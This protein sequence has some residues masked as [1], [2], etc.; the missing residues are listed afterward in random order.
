MEI[1][2]S[3]FNSV[4]EWMTPG[5]KALVYAAPAG[6]VVIAWAAIRTFF[7][8]TRVDHAAEWRARVEYGVT[9]SSSQDSKDR[10]VGAAVLMKLRDPE[11][12]WIFRP[13]K[14]L[15]ELLKVYDDDIHAVIQQAN[16]AK[17]DSKLKKKVAK[18]QNKLSKE[19][20]DPPAGEKTTDIPGSR[21]PDVREATLQDSDVDL[22]AVGESSPVKNATDNKELCEKDVAES[23]ASQ[24][25]SIEISLI[26]Q[27]RQ[28]EKDEEAGLV[29]ALVIAK[30]TFRLRLAEFWKYFVSM[31]ARWKISPQEREMLSLIAEAFS[32]RDVFKDPS[33]NERATPGPQSGSNIENQDGEEKWKW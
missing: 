7:L 25:A 10:E 4:W 15:R 14:G 9:K 17:K 13:P 18:K 12:P 28:A 30:S 31:R 21:I 3:F 19:R 24:E 33:A 29:G 5:V 6:A 2:L 11:R 32:E 8:R 1:V 27:V 23:E 26:D 20:S 22:G 16:A